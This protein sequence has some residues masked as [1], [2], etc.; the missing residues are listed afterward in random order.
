MVHASAIWILFT[1]HETL[2]SLIMRK[3]FC[4]S[5]CASSSISSYLSLLNITHISP[6][7][8]SHTHTYTHTHTHT[9][10]TRHLTP[11]LTLIILT[12]F[13]SF[14]LGYFIVSCIYLAKTATFSIAPC[15]L[16]LVPYMTGLL[17]KEN[18]R[19]CL[20]EKLKHLVI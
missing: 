20:D 1:K 16:E 3:A 10:T 13:R 15:H 8:T 4:Y 7:S 17:I 9:H 6:S 2:F 18:H 5:S 19:F 11:H 14:V 12:S